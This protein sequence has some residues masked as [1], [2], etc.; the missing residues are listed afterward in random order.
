MK[1]KTLTPQQQFRANKVLSVILVVCYIVYAGVEVSNMSKHGASTFAIARCIWYGIMIGATLLVLMKKGD[2]ENSK[3]FFAISFLFS[4]GVLVLGNGI[5]TLALVFPALVGFMIYLNARLVFVGCVGTF[6]IC[7]AKC[8]LVRAAGDM[9][10]FGYANV[11]SMALLVCVY[12]SFRAINLLITFSKEDQEVI[13]KEAERREAVAHTVASIVQVLDDDFHE[14]LVALDNITESMDVTHETMNMIAGSSE[15]SAQAVNHQVDMT[16]QIQDRLETTSVT[17]NEAKS[18]TQKMRDVIVSGKK[19]A[20]DLQEQ[21]AL[22]EQNT[23]KISDTVQLLVENVQKVSVITEAILRISSQTNLLALNASIEAA[24]AGESGRGFAVVADQIRT[25]AEETK[26]STEQI[27]AII[28]ELTSVTNETQTGIIESAE[29]VRI[30]LGK[31]KEVNESFTEVE[32][33]VLELED[34]MGQMSHQVEEV[35]KANT[36]IVDSISMLSESSEEVSAG[37][38]SSKEAINGTMDKLQGFS[39]TVHNTFKQLQI[40]KETAGE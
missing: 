24:R 11:I 21:S 15:E 13:Q 8:C 23:M 34:G 20:D 32:K 1:K 18:T 5:G 35:L 27:T 19:L 17:A 22:V 14:V 37:T 7:V 2:K 9:D 10:A 16:T 26:V 36:Q 30:Q 4:Y 12:G 31:V 28:G 40:L 29:S 39:N 25:L 38:I 6:M 33:D 3:F